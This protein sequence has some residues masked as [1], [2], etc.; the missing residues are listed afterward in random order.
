MAQVWKLLKNNSLASSVKRE[1]C[2]CYDWGGPHFQNGGDY[3][4]FT[5]FLISSE[6]EGK[7]DIRQLCFF[8]GFWE[9]IKDTE[10]PN[11]FMLMLNMSQD[12]QLQRCQ[13]PVQEIHIKTS[14][15]MFMPS[16]SVEMNEKKQG[17]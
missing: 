17:L 12:P 15:G 4:C 2:F 14:T 1:K 11:F 13:S 9:Q 3:S 8:I 7:S 10:L 6:G 16:T 5:H